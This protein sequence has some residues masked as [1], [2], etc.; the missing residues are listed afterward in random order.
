MRELPPRVGTRPGG[1]GPLHELAT[2]LIDVSGSFEAGPQPPRAASPSEEL[3]GLVLSGSSSPSKG[4]RKRVSF[5]PIAPL[6]MENPT[7]K[8][9]CL[10]DAKPQERE[11]TLYN[12]TVTPDSNVKALSGEEKE[13]SSKQKTTVTTPGLVGSSTPGGCA[14]GGQPDAGEVHA[15]FSGVWTASIDYQWHISSDVLDSWEDEREFWT[16]GGAGG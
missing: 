2:L 1:C 5:A 6:G 12:K 8:P 4:T 14:A 9:V 3:E 7:I 15:D 11:T 13:N 10:G 16:V